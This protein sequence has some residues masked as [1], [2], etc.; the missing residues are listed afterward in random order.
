MVRKLIE[1]RKRG[2][3]GWIMLLI[4]WLANGFMAL[5]LIVTINHWSNMAHEVSTAGKAGA[6]IGVGMGLTF[7]LA[8]WFFVAIITGLL[9][10]MTRGRK[11][12]IETE[13]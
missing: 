13:I 12:I 10:Y 4:F 11:E 3:F 2:F 7:L 9:A 1:R 8:T 6:A 5:W